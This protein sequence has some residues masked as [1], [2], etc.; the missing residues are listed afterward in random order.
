VLE[1]D[2]VLYNDWDPRADMVY[3][4]VRHD[5][6]LKPT[7]LLIIGT[8]LTT[9]GVRSLVRCIARDI[10]ERNG[11]V[12]L[13]TLTKPPAMWKGTINY[14]IEWD[15]DA[16]VLDLMNRVGWHQLGDSR[17]NPIDLTEC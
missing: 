4:F 12:V 9:D 17:E 10:H 13:V 8:S 16:W 2:V 7:V 11:K 1:P 6:S 5:L 15:C 14:W 3:S